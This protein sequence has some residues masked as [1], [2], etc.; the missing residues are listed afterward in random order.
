MSY[1]SKYTGFLFNEFRNV[2]EDYE[3]NLWFAVEGLLYYNRKD[4]EFHSYTHNKSDFTSIS[5][6]IIQ[7]LHIDANGG[8]WVGN[9]IE[10]V[11]YCKLNDCKS[12]KH[13]QRIPGTSNSLVCD[14]ITAF[15]GS[16]HSNI[17]IGTY[18]GLEKLNLSA[19]TYRH[20]LQGK[21]IYD[22]YEDASGNVWVII[23]GTGNNFKNSLLVRKSGSEIF[24]NVAINP[25]MK[26][27]SY[28]PTSIFETSQN[29]I[30]VGGKRLFIYNEKTDALEPIVNDIKLLEDATMEYDDVFISSMAEDVNGNIVVL[31]SNFHNISQ[32]FVLRKDSQS[33]IPC[34]ID[35]LGV[36]RFEIENQNRIWLIGSNIIAH[37][38]TLDALNPRKP[39]P[40]DLS[41]LSQIRRTFSLVRDDKDNLWFGTDNGLYKYN[42]ELNNY[43]Y[44]DFEN[45]MPHRY[46]GYSTDYIRDFFPSIKTSSDEILMGTPNGFIRFEPE[47]FKT[48]LAPPTVEIIDFK[49]FNKSVPVGHPGNQDLYI[50][51]SISSTKQISIS[52]KERDFSFE[53]VALDLASPLSNKY[54]YMLEGYDEQ[55]EYTDGRNRIA[56]YSNVPGGDY[57]FRVKASN[58]HGVWNETGTAID[59]TIKPPIWKT[60][61]FKLLSSILLI[62]LISLYV[63]NKIY[64]IRKRNI[65]LERL[66]RKR[67]DIINTQNQEL[68]AQSESLKKLNEKVKEA[69]QAKLRFFTNVSHD[70]RTPLTLILGPLENLISNKHV[71]P[72]ITKQHLLMHRNSQRLLELINQLMDFRKLDTGHLKLRVRHLDIVDFLNQ[73]FVS[74]SILSQKKNI[75]F[76]FDCDLEKLHMWYDAD[77]IEKIVSNLLSNAFKYTSENGRIILECRMIDRNEAK[78]NF[79]DHLALFDKNPYCFMI[80]VS[81][82]GIGIPEDQINQIFDRFYRVSE[83]SL[84]NEQG[85]GIGLAIIKELV[86]LHKGYISVK[87]KAKDN[88]LQYSVSDAKPGSMIS[89]NSTSFTI[90]L[91]IGKEHFKANEISLENESAEH[92]SRSKPG[93]IYSEAEDEMNVQLTENI[94][95]LPDNAPRILIVDDNSD[96]RDYVTNILQ[97]HYHIEQSVN[98]KDGL[99]KAHNL[100]FDLIISDVMMPEM[101]GIELCKSIKTDSRSS[102]IPVILLTAKSSKDN[103]LTGY[104]TGADDYIIKPFNS[105]L[106]VAR[107]KNLIESR[108]TIRRRFLK[109]IVFNPDDLTQNSVDRKILKSAYEIVEKNISNSEFNI[110]VLSKE[111]GMSER[112]LYRKLTSLTDQTPNSFITNIRLKKAAQLIL[113]NELQFA[114]IAYIVGFSDPS[115]FSSTFKKHYGVSPTNFSKQE[116]ESM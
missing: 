33:I 73:I 48:N 100:Q 65:E 70:F 52:Y 105:D 31:V 50:E 53:F 25:G 28:I 113:E 39:I 9:D 115:Y 75:N 27:D 107:V 89:A 93:Q 98:G 49:I 7:A 56:K 91:P 34:N 102:H 21:C 36:W 63:R 67:T 84:Q 104:E 51:N 88:E 79:T 82:T 85:S 66:V 24:Q 69:N 11:D 111:M 5:S 44:F 29:K 108:K 3:S 30:L 68:I 92:N 78:I 6:N 81:D 55:W 45:G 76:I 26:A 32:L 59:I 8:F 62:S 23:A 16:T 94:I 87:S 99:N 12:F 20:Y 18:K 37:L 1:E 60:I 61:W 35:G 74:F 114:E 14:T 10:G 86:E 64:A 54:A 80:S 77:K 58:S 22:V 97:N 103:Q 42:S 109:Q 106:L 71:E 110:T 83:S 41:P 38:D 4:G 95:P 46:I 19:N 90:L 112:H 72:W 43:L 47:A 17:W 13:Y 15:A 101:D 2:L 57:T 96:V 116:L 40:I